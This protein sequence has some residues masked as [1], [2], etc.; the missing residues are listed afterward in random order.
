MVPGC[1]PKV[2]YAFKKVF[3]TEDN[4]PVLLNLLDAV[5]R[6]P[7]GQRL[8][9]LD[10][11]N[12]FNEKDALDD[13]LSILDIKAR[14][15]QGRLY[16]VEMQM[17]GTP[18]F[19]QRVLY[20]WAML[21]GQ[22]LRE[23]DDY[24]DLRATIS[25]SFVNSVLFPKVPDYHLDFQL[26]ASQYPQLIF[27]AQQLIHVLEVPKFRKT[28]V[29]LA[30]PVEVW[31]YFLVHGADLDMD[32]LP[33]AL[34]TPAVQRAMEVL[35]MLTQDDLERQRYE[36][37]LKEQRDRSSFLKYAREEGFEQGRQEGLK[38]GQVDRIHLCQR[39]LKLPLTPAEELLTLSLDE[40]RARAE[41]MENQLGIV[42]P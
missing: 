28:A 13:K 1:D 36:A 29:E 10:I 26:R 27:S 35:H 33:E 19:P 17:L 24:A 38:E 22:Q 15:Q 30:D 7:T 20:Y 21:H 40:L 31:C 32:N 37:R 6:P 5:L 8:I 4:T 9:H 3:G 11:L 23:G 39:L 42:G 2:D 25:I 16:N 34:R 14:D 41:S 12:P 18:I